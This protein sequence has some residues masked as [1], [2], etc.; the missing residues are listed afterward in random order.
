MSCRN[1]AIN[2]EIMRVNT[3]AGVLHIVK[4]R[5]HEFNDVNIVTSLRRIAS[6]G[7]CSATEPALSALANK[8]SNY[9]EEKGTYLEARGIASS[10]H[11][12]AKLSKGCQS[13]LD[14]YIELV[15][16][17]CTASMGKLEAFKPQ[18][19]A[20]VMWALASLDFH[21]P[22]VMESFIAASMEKLETFTIVEIGMSI[23][24]MVKL[25]ISG[26]VNA[27]RMADDLL[28]PLLVEVFT[29]LL[30]RQ[31]SASEL[32]IISWHL[33]QLQQAHAISGEGSSSLAI[34]VEELLR[35]FDDHCATHRFVVLLKFKRND[36]NFLQALMGSEELAPCREALEAH[37]F[38]TVLPSKAKA[39][40][41]PHHYGAVMDAIARDNLTLR[42]DNVIVEPEFE[43]PVIAVLS[44]V[45]KPKKGTRRIIQFKSSD[46][47]QDDPYAI[48]EEDFEEPRSE[49]DEQE[50]ET[51]QS[52]SVQ[53]G[54]KS[55]AFRGSPLV[56]RTFIHF[57]VPSSLL[58]SRASSVHAAT[59]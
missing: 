6:L 25:W 47:I 17:L 26:D 49:G 29:P 3:I 34:A 10:L 44:R 51:G 45:S 18:G 5:V 7:G 41:H 48:G 36:R 11:S 13:F 31:V 33:M 50:N 9:L 23:T 56:K 8:L 59:A 15:E 40:L 37:G 21:P 4:T 38:D 46:S 55:C 24:A 16:R 54:S 19:L 58:D 52:S 35:S 57:P 42:I 39:F 27:K 30:E 28:R 20:M 53:S 32:E 2:K 1:R 14:R 12:L 43:E 22:E